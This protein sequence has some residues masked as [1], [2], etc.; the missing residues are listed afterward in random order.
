MLVIGEC[1]YA[2]YWTKLTYN[3]FLD[4]TNMPV[5][6]QYQCAGHWTVPICQL[7]DS[8]TMRLLDSTVCQTPS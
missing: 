1:Q 8:T 7:L 4:S 6:G 5:I 3:S 2:G